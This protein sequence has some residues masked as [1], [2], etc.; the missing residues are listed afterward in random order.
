M[1]GTEQTDSEQEQKQHRELREA[2][3]FPDGR[4]ANFPD[5]ERETAVFSR[6]WKR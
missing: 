3:E 2:R 4:A 1:A 5:L 6:A